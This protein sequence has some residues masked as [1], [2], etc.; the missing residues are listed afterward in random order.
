[1]AV[2]I[3]V[4]K[5]A[6]RNAT[7][8]SI[9]EDSTPIDPSDESGG[10]AQINFS[11]PQWDGWK[12]SRHT[13]VEFADD[14]QGI[15]KGEVN[16]IAK[17]AGM[18]SITADSRIIAM[19][20]TRQAKPYQGTLEGAIKY[21]LGLVGLKTN[22]V[23]QS[24]FAPREVVFPG[25]NA[26]VYQQIARKLCPAQGMEMALVGDQIVFRGLRTQRAVITRA[27]KLDTTIDDGERSQRTKMTWYNTGWRTNFLAYPDGG[28]NSDV[29]VFT[30]NAGETRVIES[31]E[32]G[33]SLSS[34][35]QPT[36]VQAVAP[37]Y[38]S[39]S[40]YAVAGSDGLPIPPA[41]WQQYGGSLQVEIN[42]DSRTLKIT[43]KGMKFEEYGPFSIAMASGPSTF[44]SS[45]RI[46]GTGVDMN[47][48]VQD[49]PTGLTNDDTST[50]YGNEV[51][52]EFINYL[53][54]AQQRSDW[55]F[56]HARGPRQV[57]NFEAAGINR[58]DDNGNYKPATFKDFDAAYAGLTFAQF[59]ALWAG[60]TSYDWDDYW[61][62]ITAGTFQNQAFGNMAGARIFHDETWYRIRSATNNNGLISGTAEM[63]NTF[64]D[65]DR[66]YSGM[67]FAQFDA[68]WAGRSIEE[69][70]IGPFRDRQTALPA[71]L[72]GS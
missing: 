30:V 2:T 1:M 64:S 23:V 72:T 26:D 12:A 50:E 21:Y 63:D 52:N 53:T 45:L 54:Y 66:H 8:Y 25:W 68:F 9:Q 3:K 4:N 47:K 37:E 43:M 33:S 13:Q 67:T 29:E 60:K 70:D 39:G 71:P 5:K 32:L 22:I 20:A 17:N 61:Y 56:A 10:I 31:V 11:A 44:Y 38:G 14:T 15:I 35:R 57:L 48:R 34:V 58:T 65:F 42:P 59:D 55:Q 7:S 18:L 46:I 6:V 62:D 41:M 51:D 19:S 27:R 24:D 69:F 28:W 49:R 16:T 40:V 36:C